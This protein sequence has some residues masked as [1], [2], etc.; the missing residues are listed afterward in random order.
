MTL[1]I[2]RITTIL[3]GLLILIG[4]TYVIF[5]RNVDRPENISKINN[6]VGSALDGQYDNAIAEA[7]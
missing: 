4:V 6:A 7:T 2:G 1:S 3:A 5:F